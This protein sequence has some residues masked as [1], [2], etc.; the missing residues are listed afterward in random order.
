VQYRSWH[1]AEYVIT[2]LG[3]TVEQAAQHSYAIYSQVQC[4]AKLRGPIPFLSPNTQ[5]YLSDLKWSNKTNILASCSKKSKPETGTTRE[6]GIMFR[7]AGRWS[8]RF[9]VLGNARLPNERCMLSATLFVQ[10]LS[11][12]AILKYCLYNLFCHQNVISHASWPAASCQP[13]ATRSVQQFS[14]HCYT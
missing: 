10:Q 1:I 7:P 14:P 2:Y 4:N 3:Q 6:K 12:F 8:I 13:T 5:S 11:L 9:A